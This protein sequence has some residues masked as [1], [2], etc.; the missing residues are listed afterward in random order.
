MERAVAKKA[1]EHT[2]IQSVWKRRE[3]YQ[4]PRDRKEFPNK[5]ACNAC[6]DLFICITTKLLE[7]TAP[8]RPSN[9][10][11]Y[12]LHSINNIITLPRWFFTDGSTWRRHNGQSGTYLIN[13][14]GRSEHFSQTSASC[15]NQKA[16]THSYTVS[17]TCGHQKQLSSSA[18]Q[19]SLQLRHQTCSVLQNKRQR[20]IQSR[21][22]IL[23][24]INVGSHYSG[25][26]TRLHLRCSQSL[27]RRPR[28]QIIHTT[29]LSQICTF[30]KTE[31]RPFR[32]QY[33]PTLCSQPPL[34]KQS[35]CF[36]LN[37]P[38]DASF[39]V[40]SS[41]RLIYARPKWKSRGQKSDKNATDQ[42]VWKRHEGIER[43]LGA[44]E[45]LKSNLSIRVP[46][47][48]LAACTT[49]TT[50]INGA[51]LSCSLSTCGHFIIHLNSKT[52]M[53]RSAN[54]RFSVLVIL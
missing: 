31:D 21:I 19:V 20:H 17:V 9:C 37:S 28:F 50:Q 44:G 16:A 42:S 14:N 10:Q 4:R 54:Q 51:S 49:K 13:P 33:K 39:K 45:V 27:F 7:Q 38:Q 5:S 22:K 35:R 8:H 6:A 47:F 34:N 3:N 11:R 29:A 2:L 1:Q 15:Q 43:A 46:Q 30:L 48:D 41:V 40:F 53:V 24:Y 18:F 36:R 52:K 12:S 32:F 26:R 23:N 25:K